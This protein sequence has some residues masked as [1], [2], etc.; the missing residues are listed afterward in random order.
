MKADSLT[1]STPWNGGFK[2]AF[3]AL[4]VALTGCANVLPGGTDDTA[5]EP[6]AA[7]EATPTAPAP[8]GDAAQ[9]AGAQQT[10]RVSPQVMEKIGFDINQFTNDGLQNGQAIDYRFCVPRA[11][12][13]VAAVTAID[14]SA[15]VR[16]EQ[17]GCGEREVMMVGNSHQD[18]FKTIVVGLARLPFI[19]KIER[20]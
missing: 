19:K 18:G 16:P 17:G 10:V 2:T 8:A 13:A 3:L 14:F 7:A 9:P 20:G 12:Q 5:A 6:A 4:A 1:V 15:Q 11:N